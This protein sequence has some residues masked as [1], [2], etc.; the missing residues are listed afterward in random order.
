MWQAFDRGRNQSIL[1]NMDEARQKMPFEPQPMESGTDWRV[2]VTWPD[3]E[4]EYI[5][6][7]QAE[8]E[9]KDWIKTNSRQWLY[10][11]FG[12]RRAINSEKR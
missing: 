10:D 2:R 11:Q 9:A 5:L 8:A 6:G 12:T 3:G 4:V 1:P 7:F